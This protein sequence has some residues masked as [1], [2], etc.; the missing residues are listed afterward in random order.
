MNA[1]IF[2]I[3]PPY[4]FR[5]MGIEVLP[6]D[7]NRSFNEFTVEGQAIRYGLSGI[8]VDSTFVIA[9]QRL[10]GGWNFINKN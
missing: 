8:R 7:V 4:N 1:A 3:D 2:F 10:T 9:P 5:D 6:P